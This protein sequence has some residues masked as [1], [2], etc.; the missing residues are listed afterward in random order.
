[1]P[2]PSSQISVQ[3]AQA[4]RRGAT[5]IE[6]LTVVVIMGILAMSATPALSIASEATQAAAVSETRRLLE[7][8]RAHAI[9]TGV[10]SGFI[11][12]P[13]TQQ[14][15]LVTLADGAVVPVMTS[16]GE[17]RPAVNLADRFSGATIT[18]ISGPL[19]GSESLWFDFDG[20]PHR[21]DRAGRH[22]GVLDASVVYRFD[23]GGEVTVAP[24][25]GLIR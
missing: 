12:D 15:E 18:S 7:Y 14:I 11:V 23:T 22:L 10:P 9:A 2:L 19:A 20:L 17:L 25:G 6:V 13:S 3:H 8:T 16:L 5:L 21:R 1:M 24:I 4:V